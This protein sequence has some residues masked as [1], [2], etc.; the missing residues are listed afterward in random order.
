VWADVGEATA[1][2]LVERKLHRTNTLESGHIQ[3][4]FGRPRVVESWIVT[5]ADDRQRSTMQKDYE[6]AIQK[7]NNGSVIELGDIRNFW[8][9]QLQ[10]K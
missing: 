4:D 6:R 5:N 10:G 1:Y 7:L 8:F 9:A 3:L 2:C